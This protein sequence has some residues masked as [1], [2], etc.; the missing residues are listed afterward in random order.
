MSRP[1]GFKHIASDWHA[2]QVAAQK[3]MRQNG[4][5]TKMAGFHAPFDLYT[6]KGT[7]IDVKWSPFRKAGKKWTWGF[8]LRHH[9]KPPTEVDVFVLVCESCDLLRMYGFD[10]PIYIV[11]PGSTKANGVSITAKNLLVKYGSTINDFD[12]VHEID[13]A[14]TPADR[15]KTQAAINRKIIYHRRKAKSR[16]RF[17]PERIALR[18]KMMD[19]G[20]SEKEIQK[21]L[22]DATLQNSEQK[23]K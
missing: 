17:Y 5:I 12:I 10:Y 9:G 20:R 8:Q 19:E 16:F 1:K 7:R 4:V 23:A 2:A 6:Y 15:E 3:V 13:R 22:S 21:A 11:L 18:Q 14:K